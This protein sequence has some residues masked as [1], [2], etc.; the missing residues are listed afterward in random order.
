M[1]KKAREVPSYEEKR[2]ELEAERRAE[3]HSH[4][5][6]AAP[7]SVGRELV[8]DSAERKAKLKE[9]QGERA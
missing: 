4:A 2:A 6:D 7:F 3:A 8:E 9:A 5:S 1:A